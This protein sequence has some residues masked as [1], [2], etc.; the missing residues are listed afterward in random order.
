MAHAWVVAT[1]NA[2][3]LLELR[4]LFASNAIAVADLREVGVE[5]NAESEAGI[6]SFDTFEENALAKARYFSRLLPGRVIVADDSGLAVNALGGAPGVHSKRWSGRDDLHGRALDVANNALLVERIRDQADR[7]A[8]F[9]CAA[10]FSDGRR[11]RVVRGEVA[12][13]IIDAPAGAQGFGYD[14]HFYADDLCMTLAQATLSEKERVS[15]RGRAFARLLDAL[16]G[17]AVYE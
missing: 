8:R 7:T 17:R 5:E 13:R 3:K 10:A 14:P 2:G 4:A 11:E 1:R 9:V 16:R 6:E 15:H 12:G